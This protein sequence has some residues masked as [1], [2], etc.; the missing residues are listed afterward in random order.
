M[1]LT[2]ESFKLNKNLTLITPS[3]STLEL[4]NPQSTL[5]QESNKVIECKLNFS[6]DWQLYRQ[7]ETNS[8]FNLKPEIRFPI[9]EQ[10]LIPELAVNLEIALNPAWLSEISL[11]VPDAEEAAN[12]LLRL[13]K[14]QPKAKLL[15][16][17]S[18]LG[19][20][21]KQQPTTQNEDEIGY[22]SFWSY[23]SPS[24]VQNGQVDGKP[25]PENILNL[26]Q[27][28]ASDN[29]STL[30][31]TTSQEIQTG[32]LEFYNN[33]KQDNSASVMEQNMTDILQNVSSL[34][35]NLFDF[36]SLEDNQDSSKFNLQE[37]PTNNNVVRSQQRNYQVPNYI[38]TT[39]KNKVI[40]E[41][42]QSFSK[43]LLWQLQR[44]FF[45]NQGVKAWST[46][47]V[48]NYITNNPFIAKAYSKIVFAFLQDY[49]LD[50]ENTLDLSQPVYILEIGSGSVVLL[51]IS[52]AITKLLSS[53]NSQKYFL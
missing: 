39:N 13:N 25:I 21:V 47:K 37:L 7:I 1:G 9:S 34:F 27:E 43:S 2:S 19:L 4:N 32:L 31:D 51:I 15:S 50:S 8:W 3:R 35:E 6:V 45:K 42:D 10:Q 53:F 30:L 52:E 29:L 22:Y 16:T 24:K 12:Y 28:L 11:V 20:S 5:S 48:P 26:I 14:K 49:Y 23:I 41:Q 44:N 46:G 36:D 17:E 40:L 38:P 33:L 18:W